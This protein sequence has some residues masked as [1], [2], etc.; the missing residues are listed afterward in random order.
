MAEKFLITF[1]TLKDWNFIQD[2]YHIDWI[3]CQVEIKLDFLTNL[4]MY[5][6]REYTDQ[7]K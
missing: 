2:K 6:I 3:F 7:M 4:L 1:T 5:V